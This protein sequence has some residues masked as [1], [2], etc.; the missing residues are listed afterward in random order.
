M[1]LI[2]GYETVW[3]GSAREPGEAVLDIRRDERVKTL[4]HKGK[5]LSNASLNERARLIDLI[6]GWLEDGGFDPSMTGCFDLL[7]AVGGSLPHCRQP[8]EE[9]TNGSRANQARADAGRRLA[10]ARSDPG[11]A[12]RQVALDLHR[13]RVAPADL[14]V[15]RHLDVEARDRPQRSSLHDPKPEPGT[16]SSA[17]HGVDV[18]TPQACVSVFITSRLAGAAGSGSASGRMLRPVSGM[19]LQGTSTS[20]WSDALSRDGRQHDADERGAVT[21]GSLSLSVVVPRPPGGDRTS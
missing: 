12:R 20:S 1:A 18:M 2:D 21:V 7:A 3:D 16:S 19:G 8:A 11:A 10:V 14:P 13:S 17:S 6:L 5:L 15:E 4:K 9:T